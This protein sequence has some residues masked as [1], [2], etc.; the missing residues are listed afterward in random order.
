MNR[1]YLLHQY[2]KPM[3]RERKLAYTIPNSPRA[4]AQKYVVP[5]PKVTNG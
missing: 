4:A 3:I 1:R 5:T 2:L